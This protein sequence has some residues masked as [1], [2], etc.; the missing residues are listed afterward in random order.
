MVAVEEVHVVDVRSILY[1]ELRLVLRES[2]PVISISE[3]EGSFLLCGVNSRDF[4]LTR[5]ALFACLL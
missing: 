1:P 5:A 4:F 2:V 3:I